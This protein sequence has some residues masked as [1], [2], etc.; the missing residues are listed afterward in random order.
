ME[1]AV[2]GYRP[3]FRM[4]GTEKY[5][6]DSN[7]YIID[8]HVETIHDARTLAKELKEMIGVVEH[9]LFIDLADI[10]IL[11]TDTGIEKIIRK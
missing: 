7:N 9:G 8:L 11:A 1:L 10:V 4:N 6:T 3:E 5:L 2:K